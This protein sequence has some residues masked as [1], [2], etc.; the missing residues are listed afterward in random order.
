MEIAVV[1]TDIAFYIAHS[2]HTRLLTVR[3]A[4]T[5]QE[6]YTHQV[7]ILFKIQGCIL[8]TDYGR[9]RLTG[10]LLTA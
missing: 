8:I 7:N 9:L 1:I 4:G 5:M 3:G 6:S 2:D 10:L